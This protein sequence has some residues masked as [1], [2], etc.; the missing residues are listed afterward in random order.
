MKVDLTKH[1]REGVS[2][3]GS[4]LTAV[5]QRFKSLENRYPSASQ[6]LLSIFDQAVV[7][8]TSFLTA[9]IIGR[10]TA[11]D[12][13]G[14]Y[15][16]VLSIVIVGA[17]IQDSAV[18]A[19]Y[20]VYCK[21][22]QGRELA[23]YSGSVWIHLLAVC[24]I[25]VVV[26]L[27]MIVVMSATNHTKILPGLWILLG[28]APLILL[29]QGVR[30]F[31]FANLHVRSAIALDAVVAVVQL[32]GIALLGYLGWL[33][34][35]GIFAVMG[36]ACGLACFGV[37]LLDPPKVRF[38]RDRFLPDWNLNW[39]FAKWAVRGY[40]IGNTTPYV[41]LWILGMTIG[42]AAAGVLGAC[43]TLIGMANVL[44]MGVDNVLTPQSSHA[45]ATGA[46][47]GLSRML[48]RIAAF[49]VLTLGG[50]CLFVM[51][52]G[53][54][55]AVFVFGN[56][57]HGTGGILLALALSS[58][59]YG[60]G[61]VAGNGLW[62]VDQPRACFLGDICCLIVTLIAA[63]LLIPPLGALGAALA[64]LAGMTAAAIARMTLLVRYLR[65]AAM[66]ES[67]AGSYGETRADAQAESTQTADVS[68]GEMTLL[69]TN[70][71]G[72]VI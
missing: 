60:I 57:Y 18:S 48:V 29:R 4:V 44:L 43:T 68:R 16:L 30:R 14:L 26:L 45:F 10:L 34:L 46:A 55:L 36:G 56:D 41:M 1:G 9:A 42:S 24:A 7:S 66:E 6:S 49:L 51:L 65:H 69:R 5:A 28:A 37:Y 67:S 31:A 38:V 63:V 70:S 72:A 8:G 50:F 58:L 12:E 39:A 3:R 11:P 52:T 33:S 53:D 64:T 71:P 40:L 17:A 15:Y 22:R 61:I 2:E 23:E 59:M 20:L 19:P 62:A 32:G 35:A 47:R 13:L 54:F 25:S 27:A 21:R